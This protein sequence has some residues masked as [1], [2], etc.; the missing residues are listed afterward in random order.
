MGLGPSQQ[1][2]HSFSVVLVIVTVQAK[3]GEN[4]LLLGLDPQLRVAKDQEIVIV[5]SGSAVPLCQVV[6]LLVR[7]GN[8]HPFLV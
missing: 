8:K 3:I 1:F 2:R 6:A 7:E 5:N 4:L